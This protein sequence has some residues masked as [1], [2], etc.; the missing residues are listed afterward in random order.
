MPVLLYSA[1]CGYIIAVR[2]DTGL[3]SPQPVANAAL[4]LQ[5]M[6]SWESAEGEGFEPPRACTLTVFKTAVMPALPCASLHF[7]IQT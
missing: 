2:E 5:R 1:R 6:I 7:R 4:P 3:E